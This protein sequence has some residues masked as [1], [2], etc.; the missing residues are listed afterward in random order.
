[1]PQFN[2]IEFI[3]QDLLK[4]APHIIRDYSAVQDQLVFLILIPHVVLLLF[5]YIF[6]DSISRMAIA[7]P[8]GHRG[9]KVLIG[10]AAY[11]TIMMTGWYGEILLPIFIIW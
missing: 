2:I 9:F 8:T 10:V 6:A 11:L 1:M 4:I 5:V 7:G 3:L